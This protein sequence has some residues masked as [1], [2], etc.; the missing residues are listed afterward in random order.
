MNLAKNLTFFSKLSMLNS[1]KTTGG[2]LRNSINTVAKAC[3]ELLAEEDR[4]FEQKCS[5]IEKVLTVPCYNI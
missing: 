1:S 5:L 2:A 4:F 3:E